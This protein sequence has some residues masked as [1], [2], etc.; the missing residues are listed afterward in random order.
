MILFT[1]PGETLYKSKCGTVIGLNV[2]QDCSKCWAGIGLHVGQGL[3][4]MKHS[5]KNST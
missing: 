2:G 1:V 4:K 5:S 3:V